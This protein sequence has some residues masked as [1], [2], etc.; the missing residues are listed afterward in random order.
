MSG[1]ELHIKL[2]EKNEA[3]PLNFDNEE[4]KQFSSFCAK[5]LHSIFQ[6]VTLSAIWKRGMD[7]SISRYKGGKG[8][9]VSVDHM[10]D[11][12]G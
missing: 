11:V 4:K 7:V 8:L 3:L 12:S 9:V 2:R 10:N 6:K 5:I 1:L